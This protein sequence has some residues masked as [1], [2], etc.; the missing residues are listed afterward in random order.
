[1][2]V[3]ETHP[4]VS[5]LNDYLQDNTSNHLSEDRLMIFTSKSNAFGKNIAQK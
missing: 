2:S 1:M 3:Q 5:N 4:N